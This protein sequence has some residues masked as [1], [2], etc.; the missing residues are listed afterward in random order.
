MQQH[1]WILK[2]YYVSKKYNTNTIH[3]MVPL[4]WNYKNTCSNKTY[5][6]LLGVR[7]SYQMQ[8]STKSYLGWRNCPTSWMWK[9]LHIITKIH[10]TVHFEYLSLYLSIHT[11]TQLY[12]YNTETWSPYI[13]KYSIPICI[14]PNQGLILHD[15]RNTKIRMF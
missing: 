15:N 7:E 13:Y 9:C 11:H 6:S 8:K 12:V 1:K 4:I 5:Q 10:Q 14:S 2:Y 3:Y